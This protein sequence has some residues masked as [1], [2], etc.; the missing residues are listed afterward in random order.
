MSPTREIPTKIA[1]V[2]VVYVALALA[3]TK[4]HCAPVALAMVEQWRFCVCGVA[5]N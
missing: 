5:G 1:H 4:R 3:N 2:R